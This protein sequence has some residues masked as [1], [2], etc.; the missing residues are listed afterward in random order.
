MFSLLTVVV[1]VPY[2]QFETTSEVRKGLEIS[3]S[4]PEHNGFVAG[5]IG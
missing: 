5:A 4:T 3:L 1:Q 2:L